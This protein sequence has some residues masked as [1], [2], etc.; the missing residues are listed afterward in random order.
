MPEISVIMSAFNASKHIR[1]ATESVL[2]QKD[3]DLEFLIY[4]DGSSDN[5]KKI[6]QEYSKKDKRIRAFYKKKNGGYSGFIDN[7][8]FLIKKARGKYIARLD[9]DDVCMPNRFKIQ[10][11]FLEA[12]PG[13]FLVGSGSIK[14]NEDGEVIHISRRMTGAKKLRKNLCKANR[15]YHS[16]FFFRN[17]RKI[18]YRN[19]ILYCED[20]DFILNALTKG[21]EVDNIQTSL[22]K[23]RQHA[24]SVSF[25]YTLL[26]KLF[27]DKAKEFYWERVNSGKDS[28]ASF[29]SNS[30]KDLDNEQ[31]QSKFRLELQIKNYFRFNDLKKV[32][33]LAKMYVERYGY[34]NRYYLYYLFTFL[35]PSW[36]A[37]V[38][39]ILWY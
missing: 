1:E 19:K 32:R 4:E 9:A 22:I 23:Y 8:N 11:E 2:S 18:W 38:K 17:D 27:I 20:Y 21:Y 24:N 30:F 10:K 6:I 13:I 29:D 39:K 35:S 3:V 33:K 25:K 15:F 36:V 31:F 28:Y 7:L 16:S 12:H 37:F 26:Q 14:I 5:T 34:F